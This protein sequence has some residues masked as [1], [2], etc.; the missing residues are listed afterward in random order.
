MG[1]ILD[2]SSVPKREPLPDGIYNLTCESAECKDSKNG[3]PM[4]S[5]RFREMETGSAVFE[6][7]V[8]TPD[9]LWKLQGYLNI[10][11]IEAD[12]QLDAEELASSIVGTA[13]QAKVVQDDYNG[14][15]TNKVKKYMMG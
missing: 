4:L 3:K 15:I 5:V 11:G 9:C 13:V 12:G 8:L 14:Q 6:N 7:F 2:F 1:M 10:L